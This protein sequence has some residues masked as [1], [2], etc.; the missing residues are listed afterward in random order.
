MCDTRAAFSLR[1]LPTCRRGSAPG[2]PD[3]RRVACKVQQIT[4][5]DIAKNEW[6]APGWRGAYVSGQPEST[7]T[8][9]VAGVTLLGALLTYFSYTTAGP[10][11]CNNVPLMD[12]YMQNSP[13]VQGPLFVLAGVSHFYPAHA[14]FCSF[15]PHR[16]AWGF[17]CVSKIILHMIDVKNRQSS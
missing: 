9:I 3:S 2:R 5:E 1:R 15:Y 7:Q 6:T 4:N 14:L 16:G 8:A 12:T 11:I 17:W 10:W 13:F